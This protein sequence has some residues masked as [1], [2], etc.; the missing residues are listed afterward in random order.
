VYAPAPLDV[1]ASL[2]LVVS[3]VHVVWRAR[4]VPAFELRLRPEP[5]YRDHAR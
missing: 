5:G 4:S 3:M 2:V 1:L